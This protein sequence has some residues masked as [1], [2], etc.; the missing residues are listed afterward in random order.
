VIIDNAVKIF[1]TL[2][3]TKNPTAI[4]I[5]N[6]YFAFPNPQ[7]LI[8]LERKFTMCIANT[9]VSNILLVKV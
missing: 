2:C 8:E 5:P 7:E 3:Y 6:Y 9:K 1:Y 4:S